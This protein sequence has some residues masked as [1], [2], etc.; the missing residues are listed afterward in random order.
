MEFR[1][2]KDIEEC[3]KLWEKFSPKTSAWDLWD[4]AFSFH[5]GYNAAPYFILGMKDN[6][7][8]GILHLQ[9][10]KSKEEE[11]YAFFG[12]D[13][14]ERITFYIKDKSLVN[15]F[16]EQAPEDT[17][18]TYIDPS[19]KEFIKD[20]KEDEVAYSLNLE[21]YENIDD[22]FATFNKK[23]RK[24]IRYD[25]RQLEK[26]DYKLIW[27]IKEHLGRLAELNKLKFK[28]ESNFNEPEFHESMRLLLEAAE[29]LNILHLLSIKIDKNIEAAQIAL[30]Y[31]NTYYVLTGGSNP[32]IRNLGKLLITEHIKNAIN[33]K[34][35]TIDFMS[36]ESGWKKLWNLDETM[37]YRFEK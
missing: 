23:H 28:E 19:E 8:I 11:W 35:E 20:I 22:Y 33:L 3:R 4:I 31:N 25:L 7:E 10:E 12:G 18:L 21:K 24:N 32:E 17:S 34:A 29:K 15:E 2:T 6:K 13:Y 9:H 1:T 36:T 27:N 37:L 30:F 16:L 14:P 26:L 5:K